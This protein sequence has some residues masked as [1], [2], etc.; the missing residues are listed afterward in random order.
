VKTLHPIQTI[1]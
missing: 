1:L